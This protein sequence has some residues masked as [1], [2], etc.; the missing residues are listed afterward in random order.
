MSFFHLIN[1]RSEDV[2]LNVTLYLLL[3][4]GKEQRS[5]CVVHGDTHEEAVSNSL[6]A[7]KQSSSPCTLSMR[8]HGLVVEQQ[9]LVN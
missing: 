7:R 1:E 8:M 9:R 5:R 4:D 2:V 6:R 3:L